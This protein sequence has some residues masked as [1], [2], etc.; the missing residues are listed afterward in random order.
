MAEL[1]PVEVLGQPPDTDISRAHGE[2]IEELMDGIDEG[3]AVAERAQMRELLQE[4]GGILSVS[5][6]HMGKNGSRSM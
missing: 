4:F 3:V 1:Q 2:C 5:E 6:Y